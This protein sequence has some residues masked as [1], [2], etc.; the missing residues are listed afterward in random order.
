MEQEYYDTEKV[1]LSQVPISIPDEVSMTT[2]ENETQI[3]RFI[4]NFGDETV[5]IKMPEE[6]KQLIGTGTVSQ[7][8]FSKD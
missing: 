6:W 2:R 7:C 3:F 8:A 5:N 1:K 4:Q